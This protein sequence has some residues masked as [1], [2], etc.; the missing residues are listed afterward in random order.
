MK[1]YADASQHVKS[2]AFKL[3]D[4]VLGKW[5]RTNKFMSLFDPNPYR[6]IEIRGS[7]VIAARD[8]H[9]ITRNSSYFKLIS[10]ECYGN[11]LIA[12]KR[13]LEPKKMNRAYT[14]F[15][16]FGIAHTAI[17]TTLN[18][19]PETP[20]VQPVTITTTTTTENLAELSAPAA[21]DFGSHTNAT[22]PLLLPEDNVSVLTP[23]ATT[24]IPLLANEGDQPLSLEGSADLAINAATR[25][26]SL[27][28]TRCQDFTKFYENSPS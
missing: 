11:A 19:P 14:N 17:T 8:G 4:P 23:V 28:K 1:H 20:N 6:I 3:N 15:S 18:T 7:M 10:E 25:R 2:R 16:T 9:Q 22:I 27:R 24:S 21:S 13:K 26:T 12:M 5:L